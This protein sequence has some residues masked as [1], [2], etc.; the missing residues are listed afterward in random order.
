VDEP[1]PATPQQHGRRHYQY[2]SEKLLAQIGEWLELEKSKA[3]AKVKRPHL[4]RKSKSPSGGKQQ[5]QQQ[6]QQQQNHEAGSSK[7][8]RHHRHDSLDSQSSEMA[9][10]RLQRILEESVATMGLSSVPRLPTRPS[11]RRRS[12]RGSSRSSI[13][14]IGASSDTDYVDGDAIVPECDVWIDNSKTM[15]YGDRGS[16]TPNEQSERAQREK[17]AWTAFKNDIIRTAHTLRLKGWRRVPLDD[18]DVID[19]ERLSGALTNAVYVVTPPDLPR[20]EGKRRPA[21]LLLRIYGPQAENLIDRE[22]ELKVLQRLARKKIGPRLLGTF[23]NG[24]FEQ[25]LNAHPLTAD[26]I[27]DPGISKSIAKRMRE[28]H[29][30]IEL[31]PHEREGGPQ[32]WRA[33]DQWKE[34]VERIM[35]FLDRQLDDARKAEDT[36]RRNSVMHAWKG[37]GYIC[38]VP[39]PQFRDTV[40]RFRA[41]LLGLYA[42]QKALNEQLVFAHND[43]GSSLVHV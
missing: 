15:G 40:E 39:W 9:L 18:G 35:T 19:V 21:K 31:L 12:V 23:K 8:S 27:R 22:N 25:F 29:D 20:E 28:L 11:P 3:A 4:R 5:E 17:E 6:Q 41:Y 24:R 10:E 26:V 7:D 14:R 2:H 32:V 16:C 36:R 13:L 38:G 33:W 42:D 43:V 37:N 30:G 34:N 1:P